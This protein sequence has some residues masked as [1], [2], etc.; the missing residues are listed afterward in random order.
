LNRLLAGGRCAVALR[1]RLSDG[2]SLEEPPMSNDGAGLTATARTDS[3]RSQGSESV[4][5]ALTGLAGASIEWYDFLLFAT[6]AA[7]VF[8]T[9]FFPATLSPFVALIASFSTFAVGFISRPVGAVVFGYMGDKLGRKAA[10]AAALVLMGTATTLIGL[11]PSYRTAGAVAPLALTLLR[12]AQGFAVGGQWGGAILLAT[13]SVSKSRRGLYGSIA[14]AGLPAGIVLA[15]LA[16]LVANSATSPAAFM[17]YGWRIPFLLSIVLVGLG[18]FI[19]FKGEDTVAFRR[20]RQAK[21]GSAASVATSSSHPATEPGATRPFDGG[22]PLLLAFRL[23]PRTI[24]LAAGANIGGMLAF[25]ILITYVIAYGT[26][27]AGLQL[28]RSTMLTALLIAQA[29]F[30]PSTIFAGRLSDRVGRR[31]MFVAGLALTIIWGFILFPMLETRSLPLVT[32]AL[33]IGL[34]FVS[35]S[36][37]PLAAMLAALFATRVRYCAVSLSYQL[38]AIV[39][40]GLAPII[41][42]GLYARY[43]NNIAISI[44]MGGACAFSLVCVSMLNTTH[45]TDLDNDAVPAIA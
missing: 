7:L 16:L 1:Q 33:S 45:E 14:Q 43:H 13:E 32:A 19:H 10:F 5:H 40:G 23:Y 27:A 35:L 24:L 25:Y 37:G 4:K 15:N 17:S 34:I 12:L 21:P 39:G 36:Y 26:S 22:S 29:T 6:A 41:A 44:Y 42:T 8:P 11:I 20:L 3:S 31:K 28:P 38:S 18:S 9:E 30:L 2:Q